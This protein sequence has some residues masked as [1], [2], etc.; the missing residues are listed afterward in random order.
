MR[1]F[2]EKIKKKKY[3]FTQKFFLKKKKMFLKQIKNK[4]LSA[5]FQKIK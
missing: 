2:I 3:F 5:F 4:L 1:R